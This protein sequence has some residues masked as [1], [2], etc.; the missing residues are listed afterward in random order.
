MSFDLA[1]VTLAPFYLIAKLKESHKLNQNHLSDDLTLSLLVYDNEDFN[2]AA[3]G[4][5]KKPKVDW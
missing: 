3:V 1:G 4:C 5:Y 2:N